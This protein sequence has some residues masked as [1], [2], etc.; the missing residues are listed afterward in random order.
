MVYFGI[1]TEKII[2]YAEIHLQ[3]TDV[4]S[5]VQPNAITFA[6]VINNNINI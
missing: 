4:Y 5:S 2:Q 1:L 3:D 6:T